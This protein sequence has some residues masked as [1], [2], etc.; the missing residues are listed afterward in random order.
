M[1][2]SPDFDFSFSGLKT[3]ILYQVQ[4]DKNWRQKIPAYAAEFQ[5]AVVDVLISKTL[6]AAQKFKART[7]ILSGGVS[8]NLELRSQLETAVKNKLINTKFVRPD[9]AY[10]TDNAAM[11]GAAGYFKFKAQKNW[12]LTKIKINPNWELK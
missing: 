9:L 11:I 6:K 10:T 3:A 1:L 8:A 5:Q 7:V 2:N 12:P 4:A